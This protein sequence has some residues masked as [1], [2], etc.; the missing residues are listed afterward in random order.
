[1]NTRPAPHESRL[2]A[3]QQ[4]LM[5]TTKI[6]ARGGVDFDSS[7]QLASPKTP[8][9][10]RDLESATMSSS[11]T[12]VPRSSSSSIFDPMDSPKPELN[13]FQSFQDWLGTFAPNTG[14]SNQQSGASDI[15][16]NI[17]AR[18][19]ANAELQ[20][21]EKPVHPGALASLPDVTT[22]SSSFAQTPEEV[23]IKITI[24]DSSD[25]SV[26]RAEEITCKKHAQLYEVIE[27]LYLRG[28]YFSTIT[29]WLIRGRLYG[30]LW[31]Q[32]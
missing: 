6:V 29:Y 1:M 21:K 25:T 10:S 11:T 27:K 28:R 24:S 17:A 14:E 4:Y 18:R 13:T 7:S 22:T 16:A 5:T 12:L 26:L 31:I 32:D 3:I 30:C 9:S 19:L 23:L 2:A 15:E 20:G 8:N